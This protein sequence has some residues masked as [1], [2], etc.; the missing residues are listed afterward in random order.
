M[1][2]SLFSRLRE[3][4]TQNGIAA[5]RTSRTSSRRTLTIETLERRELLAVTPLNNMSANE[6]TGE[7]PQSKIWEYNDAWYSVMPDSSGT[8]V[9]QLN[10]STWQKQLQLTADNGYHADVKVDGNLAHV[11]LFDGSSSRLASIE[12][13]HGIDNQYEMW[14]LRPSLVNVAVNGSAE[15]AVIDVDSTGRM[16][17]CYDTSS[18]IEVRYADASSQYSSWS[19]AITVGSG[20]KS[21]DIGSIIAMPSGQIGVMWSNQN[22]ER[23]HFRIHVDGADPSSWLN[24][25]V[26]AGQSAQDRGNGM[27]DDHINL[28]VGS[29]GTIYAAVKTSYDS[30]GYPRMCLLV[31]RPSGQ[32]DNMYTVDTIGTR[33]IVML[34]EAA[35]KVIVAYT[36][37]DSGGT[38]YYKESP[39]G[40]ISFGSRQTLISSS[41]NNVSSVKAQFVDDV[42]AIA[43][44]G[45]SIRGSRY[46]VDGPIGNPP[47]PANQAPSVDAGANATVQLAA[48]AALNGTVTDDGNPVGGSLT[49]SWTK[50]SGPGTVT[51][52][53]ASAID[54]TANF[55]L[56]GSYVLRL[57][58]NDSS[59]QTSDTVTIV[60]EAPVIPPTNQP[61]TVSAGPDRTIGL[62]SSA[63]LD[64]TVS[65]DNLPDGGVTQI[66]TKVSGP[67]TVTF[68]NAS[69]VDTTA[70]FSQAGTYVLR[71]TA[72]DGTLSAFDE[73][74][75]VVNL[76]N[77]PVMVSF[78]DGVSGYNGTRDTK[79]ATKSA[80][81]N[82]GTATS[83]D[84]DGSPDISALIYWDLTQIPAGSEVESVTLQFNV[85]NTSSSA[86]DLYEVLRAWDEMTATWNQAA[87]GSAWGTA[88]ALNS[89]DRG[90]TVLG[91]FTP[92]ATGLRT[93]TLNA[94][95]IAAVQKWIND[96]ATNR[97]FIIQDYANSSGAD[98]STS[99]VST[100]SQ[101]PKISITYRPSGP[102]GTP[103]NEAPTVNA[104][105][106]QT[107]QLPNSVSLSGT[108]YDD[109][110]PNGTLTRTWTKF[111]GPGTV[112]FGNAA[113]N[114]T[115][116]S[117]S[118]AGTYVLRLTAS[119]GSLSSFDDVTIIVQ[120]ASPT[121]TAPTVSAGVDQ[122][123]QLPNNVSL[124]GTTN[125]DGL[126]NDTLTRTWT[127]FAGPGTVTFGNASAN[128]TT[129][130]FS[131]AGTYVLRL[132][133]S[134]GSL[135]SFDDVTIVVENAPAVNQGPNVDAGP[136]R[137]ITFG[138]SASLD[139]TVTDD[140]LPGSDVTQT[141]T[142]VSGPG[143]VSFGNANAVD[144]TATFSQ[145]GT[146]ILRLTASDGQLSSSDT[147][148]VVV[149]T[150]SDPVTIS[151]QDGVSGYTGTLDTKLTTNSKNTN[152]GS[153]TTL[154]FDGKPDVSVLLSWDLSQIPAGSEIVSATIQ[155]N[156]TNTSS[157]A[158]ELYAV[159]RAWDESSATWNQASA[160]SSWGT[161][162]AQNASDR[163][164]TVLGSITA[165]S[166]GLHQIVL[167]AA[168]IAAV[169]GW[170]NNPS[171]NFGFIVQDYANSSGVDISTSE[172][173]TVSQRPRLTVAYR[174]AGGSGATSFSAPTNLPPLVN[175]GASQRIQLPTSATLSP[176]LDETAGPSGTPILLWTRVSGPG[177][178]TFGNAAAA[179][180]TASFSSPGTYVL[181]LT[182]GD[183]EFESF[184]ELAIIVDAAIV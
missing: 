174:P 39:L 184:D 98:I 108:T 114:N 85:T 55:S 65:D 54:T 141:W 182:V 2:K 13:D 16:W 72:S 139:G 119:D 83:I 166:T 152:Y 128:S 53:N 58:A 125:D 161:A 69:A 81:T 59:L 27:A 7:K 26:A 37:S 68:G 1:S 158:Y 143:T 156:V 32:W 74:T 60:V 70:T 45:S 28:A 4:I 42:V 77:D 123:I 40:N 91:S 87:N 124:S 43:S 176:T 100:A 57:T 94:A 110:L 137:S 19:A 150:T 132:T 146:Y 168:G 6:D 3:R 135:S 103:T 115:T 120:S 165:S 136:N 12:Y 175:A 14:S 62:T 130:S 51:F 88:G 36:Q 104:G 153:A 67:G 41:S 89:S 172:T 181:R 142:K 17:V 48:G 61:P 76:T 82:Y 179:N 84:I 50:V 170:V 154:D 80:N 93:I 131:Q 92:S 160:G 149:N 107:I 159:Q 75:V 44:S 9:W 25:E 178:V 138:N 33:P 140:N 96:P 38:I 71:L 117:F 22:T 155:V 95:G 10:G 162:G 144:T 126:P 64:G 49:T 101:R 180:T 148:S 105:T 73:M 8:W 113:A 134:D 164:T 106:D 18:T 112:T 147:M 121:N 183:G 15:T 46:V 90:S 97:G 171:S 20:I 163:G 157:Q 21:D 66:W 129:A 30:S 34:S 111:S 5:R 173:A 52:G 145:P 29:D 102:I 78:Q 167:N 47:P 31:R 79:I 99:E 169:Q 109:N 116:A 11:L 177:T 151:L 24:A 35:N 127:K 23:F 118:Q 56:A 63:S 86:Y 133:A 122:T